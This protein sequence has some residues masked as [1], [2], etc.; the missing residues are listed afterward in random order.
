MYQLSHPLYAL[1]KRSRFIVAVTVACMLIAV[2]ATFLAPRQYRAD[3]QV[4]VIAKSSYGVDPYTVV[5]SAE[6]V[7]EGLVFIMQTS[8]FYTKVKQ[9]PGAQID[10]EYFDKLPERKKRERWQKDVVGSVVFGTGVL[11]VSAYHTD[12]KQAEELV[13]AV[14]R[15]LSSRGAQYVGADVGITV[16]NEAVSTRWPARPNVFVNAFAAAV[17]GFIISS[18]IA[19]RKGQQ[20]TY[21]R[22]Q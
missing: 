7:A 13:R 8:D 21:P 22:E 16:V 4:L 1:L 10:W 2:I 9:E 15:T 14:T 3:S 11:N 18:I 20:T 12:P 19:I 6:R 5:K 17:L